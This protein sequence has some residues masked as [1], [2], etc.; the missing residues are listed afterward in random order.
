MSEKQGI[1]VGFNLT[2]DDTAAQAALD[3]LE[4]RLSNL[5]VMAV[6]VVERIDNLPATPK[7][8][9]DFHTAICVIQEMEDE[10]RKTRELIAFRDAE[11]AVLERE[12]DE[13]ERIMGGI[14]QSAR[15]HKNVLKFIKG[16]TN[17]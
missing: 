3:R 15:R 16:L 9:E 1:E 7:V 2:L 4:D 6:K 11:I 12:A 10:L 8:Y 14:L 5:D 13:R 17:G